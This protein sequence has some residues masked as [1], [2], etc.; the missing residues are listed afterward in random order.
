MRQ[1]H[2]EFISNDPNIDRHFATYAAY[3]PAAAAKRALDDEYARTGL[4]S[5]GVNDIVLSAW[6]RAG[7][8]E[9]TLS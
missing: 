2:L 4:Y 7:P 9:T 6:V 8:F 3:E 1:H 5:H